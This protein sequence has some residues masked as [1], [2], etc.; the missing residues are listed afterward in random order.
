[1]LNDLDICKCMCHDSDCVRHC[2]PCCYPCEICGQNIKS[3]ATRIH[4]ENCE[5]NKCQD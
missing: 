2:K 4:K 1:M 5:V 3:Y